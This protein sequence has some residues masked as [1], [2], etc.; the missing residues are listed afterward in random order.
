VLLDNPIGLPGKNRLGVL[1]KS[2]GEKRK[3]D[4]LIKIYK[5]NNQIASFTESFVANSTTWVEI[6]LSQAETL[7]GEYIVTI[8]DGEFTYDNQYYFVI[9]QFKKSK[10]YHVYDELPSAFV[11]NVYS[12]SE[13]FELKMNSIK[14][15]SQEEL[16]RADLI[17]FDHLRELP[18]WLSNQL[19]SFGNSILILPA[20]SPDIN[21]YTRFVNSPIFLSTDSSSYEVDEA[22][23]DHPYFRSVFNKKDKETNL[24]W[25]KST[26]S[27][28]AGNDVIL[29]SRLGKSLLSQIRPNLYL[30]AAPLEDL[31]TNLHKH[32]LFLPLMY[33]LSLAH[34]VSPVLA[35]TIGDEIIAIENDS[36][37][38]SGALRLESEDGVIVP[39]LRTGNGELALEIP[40]VLNEP[41][42]YH[43][44]SGEDMLASFAFN[45]SSKESDINSVTDEEIRQ[46]M[47][48]RENVM[49][50]EIND[51]RDYSEQLASAN[52]GLPLWKYALLLALIFLI[53]ELTLLRVFR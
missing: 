47:I 14:N 25:M 2:I 43:L 40:S 33:K 48:G 41:G 35:Y 46:W 1:V 23:L 3:E 39:S 6:D 16:L 13:Y 52:D 18:D 32:A 17:V 9:D 21:S 49:F 11:K 29:K 4:V 37:A 5:D 34:R 27:F 38:F 15:L 10:V 42:F 36:L 26:I 51:L 12:N 31:Y 28:E 44:M 22:S 30:L 45:L 50:D 24:P 20:K 7:S 8:D 53:A 19:K